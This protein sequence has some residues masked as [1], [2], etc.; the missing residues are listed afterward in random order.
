MLQTMSL[1]D[2]IQAQ[3]LQIQQLM[4]MVSDL[5]QRGIVA[6]P[7][8]VKVSEPDN[9]NGDCT[10]F[11]T[12][13]D[14]LTLFFR[15]NPKYSHDQKIMIALSYIKGGHA[16]EWKHVQ[17]EEIEDCRNKQD[18]MDHPFFDEEKKKVT[19]EFFISELKH[20]FRDHN[21][22]QTAQQHLNKAI[23]WSMSISLNLNCTL[24]KRG[25][26]KMLS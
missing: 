15:A 21:E 10:K 11:K 3:A 12:F 24:V 22:Q 2:M 6:G 25:T 18:S 19:Y 26:M 23:V 16:D 17:M 20:V 7:A 1:Q 14:Q 8:K 5:M 9:F 13:L 4:G